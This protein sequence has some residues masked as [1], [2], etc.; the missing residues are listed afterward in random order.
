L[1]TKIGG[2]SVKIAGEHSVRSF[3]ETCCGF[4]AAIR[5]ECCRFDTGLRSTGEQKYW[6]K[7]TRGAQGGQAAAEILE[8]DGKETAE[9]DEEIPESSEE[10]DQEIATAPRIAFAFLKSSTFKRPHQTSQATRPLLHQH[11][12]ISDN[13]FLPSDC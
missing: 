4:S 11:L 3:Y 2:S 10:G 1:N 5:F 6:R 9:S 7:R 13:L 8:K 12:F